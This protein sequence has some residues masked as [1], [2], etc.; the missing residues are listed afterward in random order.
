MGQI[1]R[2]TDATIHYENGFTMIVERISPESKRFGW[3]LIMDDG[4]VGTVEA[5]GETEDVGGVSAGIHQA[6]VAAAAIFSQVDAEVLEGGSD[7]E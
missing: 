5:M 4:D 7:G 1:I 6:M 2:A 3:R